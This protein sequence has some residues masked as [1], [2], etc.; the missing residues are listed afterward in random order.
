MAND[1][2]QGLGLEDPNYQVKEDGPVEC[3][4]KTFESDQARRDYYLAILAEKLKDPEFR[5]IEGF[6]IGDDEDILELSDP[7]Y[8]TACPNPFVEDFVRHYGRP[9]DALEEYK[10]EPY[11]ADVSE[12]KN[13]PIYNAHSYHTKV[14][15]K[16]IMRYVLHY[17]SPGDI[18]F[19]GFC[20][21][22]MT[23]VAAQQC[24]NK[25]VVESLGYRVL[26]D[27]KILSETKGIDGRSIWEPFSKLGERKTILNDLS[28]AATL[29][30]SN[31]NAPVNKAVFESQANRILGEIENEYGWMYSTLHSDEKTLGS[32]NFTVWS[33]VFSCPECATEIIFWDVAVDEEKGSVRDSFACPSCAAELKKR[34]LEKTWVNE[35]DPILEKEVRYSKQKPVLINYSVPGVTKRFE[36]VPDKRDLEIFEKSSRQEISGWVPSVEFVKGDKTGEPIRLGLTH[37]HH[38]YT[39]KNLA[40]LSA[41]YEKVKATPDASQHLKMWL[42]SSQVWGT[43]QNRLLTS[44]YFKKRG[45]VIG[46]TLQGTLYVSSLSVETNLIERFRLRMKSVAH[47]AEGKSSIIETSSTAKSK[48]SIPS[49]SLDYVFIDPPFGSNLMYSELNI[50]WEAWNKVRTSILEEAIESRSQGKGSEEYRHIMSAAFENV[51]DMLKPGRWM[52]V[53]FSNTS[54]IVWNVIQESISRA[55]F[56]ISNISALNKTHNGF[57]AV[58]NP[59]SVKQDLVISAYK[60]NG[61]FEERFVNESDSDGVWDFVRTHLGYLLVVKQQAGEIVKIPERDPRI[62]FDQV[63]SYFVRNLRDVPVSSKEFQVGLLE[64]FVERDGMIFLP[65]QVAEYDKARLRGRQLK[66]LSIFVDDEASAIE[67]LRQLLNEKPQP[68][69]DVHPKFINELSGWKK[70]EEQLE[71][72]KLLEQNFIKYD[73]ESPLP[74]QIHSYLSTNFKEMRNLSKDDPLL[75]KKAKDRWYVPNLDREEDLQKLRER[76]LLKQF[77]EYRA[78]TGRRLKTVRMEAVRCGFKKAWQERDY[79]TIIQ[80]AEK[81][82]QNLL[83]ED[84]KLLMWYDQAQ[85]RHSDESL[86]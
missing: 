42:T 7:P 73:G 40:V 45:G 56:I 72:S 54:A 67:W 53:E 79:P 25:T 20:G 70:S 85:T 43:K 60:P 23:G 38:M 47:A 63:V 46:Q 48:Y 57:N 33:D 34:S 15:H 27:G 36:K 32:I 29:I 86:F 61:G 35:Y 31:F 8:Y 59:T 41:F 6:P 77:E 51:Y 50:V 76:D 58:T 64:R 3:L 69:Q 71:L 81:I 13:D 24:G 62:I 75:I 52:T 17:T 65:D 4:G 84:Q 74:P 55:G 22:G 28:P 26:P 30:A 16:A 80:V 10:R 11:A 44:N 14:P 19:D 39:K 66:Q 49:N 1:M 12:G 2:Q 68:Y 9:Y 5:A 18:V 78:H 83:Q 21:T 82:P 37:V